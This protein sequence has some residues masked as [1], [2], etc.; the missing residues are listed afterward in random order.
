MD[1]LPAEQH[2]LDRM[3]QRRP[4]LEGCTPDILALHEA[5]VNAYAAGG[6]LLVCGNGGSCADAMHIA[7][8]LCKGFLRK[9]PLPSQ[10]GEELEGLPFG[11]E[12]A[13]H[14]EMGLPT[15]TI[16]LNASLSSAV[17]NDSPLRD[18]AFAQETLALA[19]PEDVVMGIST[20]G[21]ADNCLMALST[22]K[23]L[24]ATT[25]GLTGPEGGAIAAAVDIAIRAPGD[26]TP[27]IQESHVVIYHTV[28]AM[29]EAHYF[30]E[31]R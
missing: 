7:A 2:E 14:L 16:G 21:N 27:V 6:K 9:R 23:A 18:M 31:K 25:V 24:G 8:E 15:I 22:A 17:D 10:L 11:A 3:R 20:S 12:L 30:T 13:S 28:C 5:L 26:S 29:A 4:D 19:N 1:L